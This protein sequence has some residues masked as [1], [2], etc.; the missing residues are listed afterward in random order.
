MGID[1]RG[2]TVRD[3]WAHKNVIV[4]GTSYS[5]MIPS[6]GVLMLRIR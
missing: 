2:A 3:V 1:V 6:H 5:E 4:R